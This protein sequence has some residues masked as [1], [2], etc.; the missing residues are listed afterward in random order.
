MLVIFG[1]NMVFLIFVIYVWVFDNRWLIRKGKIKIGGVLFNFFLFLV[2]KE[3]SCV[4]VFLNN[5][6]N[7]KSFIILFDVV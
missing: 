1:E 7:I 2:N 6:G 4:V 5:K 3:Y